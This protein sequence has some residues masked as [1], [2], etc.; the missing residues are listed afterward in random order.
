[1]AVIVATISGILLV[2]RATNQPAENSNCAATSTQTT[3]I[4][5]STS[6]SKEA[7]VELINSAAIRHGIDQHL[8]LETAKCESSLR[9]HVLGDGG[10]SYGLWQI[11]LKSHPD[12]STE[13]ALDPVWATEWSAVKFKK[14]PT[15]WTCYRSLETKRLET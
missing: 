12:V 5:R 8:F 7:I 4:P 15:I 2:V 13:Q 9:P 11:H 3:S 1:V 10:E 6:S 14:D